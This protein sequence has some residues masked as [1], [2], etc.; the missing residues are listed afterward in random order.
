MPRSS[1][2]QAVDRFLQALQKPSGVRAVHLR[3]ME[4]ERELQRRF[5]ESLAVFA[6]NEKGIVE[7]AAVHAHGSV[8][9][10]IHD[11]GGADDHVV[12]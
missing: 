7:N 9:L 1:R 3:V 6:P 2:S 10:R 5:E 4:L 11:G 8:K 12:C